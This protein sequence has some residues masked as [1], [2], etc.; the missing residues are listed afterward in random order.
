MAERTIWGNLAADLTVE[1]AGK[2]EVTKF[3]VIENT[4][5]YR[6]GEWVD[7]DTPTTHFIEAWFE[8]SKSA[9]ANL[10]K[11]DG[12]IVYGKER[13]ESWGAED[14]RKFGRVIR[15]ER[16]GIIPRRL[17]ADSSTN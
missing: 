4:R 9:A 3:R 17:D 13:S 15:A 2:A 12:A 11:G 14:D 1:Q 8:L 7:D 5:S 16:F 6:G 10:S